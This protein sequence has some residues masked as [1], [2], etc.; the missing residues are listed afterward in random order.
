MTTPPVFFTFAGDTPQFMGTVTDWAVNPVTYQE[1]SGVL[2]SGLAI[3]PGRRAGFYYTDEIDQTSR[4]FH[5]SED[6]L[7]EFKNGWMEYELSQIS[8]WFPDVSVKMETYPLLPEDGYLVHY[9][10][11]TNQRCF[12]AAGFG[13][14]TE[15]QGRFEL[16]GESRRYFTADNAKGNTVEI[17]KNRALVRYTD[18]KTMRVATS[19]DADFDLGSAKA[20]ADIYPS[21]FLGSAPE[22]E[23]DQ[24]VKISAAIEPGKVLDGFILA[25][26]DESEDV[27]DK[28]L[29]M[30]DPIGYIK[31]QIYAKFAC[32]DVDTPDH[33]LDLTVVPNVIALDASWHKDAFN[34]GAFAYH[35]PFLGWRNWYAPTALHWN[36]RVEKTIDMWMSYITR[37]DIKD[38]YVYYDDSP[39]VVGQPYTGSRC[40]I[41][42]AVGRYLPTLNL[43]TVPSTDPIICRN[44]LW[45]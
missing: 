18:G 39:A 30:E 36:E 33:P 28:W 23:D 29:A 34:H 20:M 44:A 10:I 22:N 19:F 17:G 16:K 14:I 25:I 42:N 35:N 27:L 3:T 1:K 8:S 38:E 12:F 13:G 24:V 5:N 6:V 45:T 21:T 41:R 9:R 37:G 11:T 32:I 7:A 43:T 2:I 4:W 26:R 40:E 31:Q 15:M